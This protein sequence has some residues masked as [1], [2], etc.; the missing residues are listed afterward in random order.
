MNEMNW[1]RLWW[2][3]SDPSVRTSPRGRGA[4]GDPGARGT[5]D[6]QHD[7]SVHASGAERAP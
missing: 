2:E 7:A 3:F 1:Q 6:A 4:E 5:L